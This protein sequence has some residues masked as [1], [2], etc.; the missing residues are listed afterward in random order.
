M[1]I[2]L[3]A[4]VSELCFIS[5]DAKRSEQLCAGS[6]VELFEVTTQG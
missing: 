5:F 3:V 1:A 6:V 2:E 4:G